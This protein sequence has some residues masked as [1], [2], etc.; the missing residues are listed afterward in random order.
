MSINIYL[1]SNRDLPRAC[2]LAASVYLKAESEVFFLDPL[3]FDEELQQLLL[4][5]RRLPVNFVD[6]TGSEQLRAAL[7]EMKLKVIFNAC[8]MDLC[9]APDI[10]PGYCLAAADSPADCLQAAAAAIRL[11]YLFMA[12]PRAAVDLSLSQGRFPMLWFGST[13]KLYSVTG[14]TE[15]DHY[16][17]INSSAAL[18]K[19]FQG[20]GLE[21]DYLV[22]YNSADLLG[23]STGG[24]ALGKLRVRG[25]S[26]LL[27]VLSSYRNI[28]PYDAV[29][30]EPDPLTIER[31]LNDMVRNIGLKPRY[32][33]VLASPAVIPFI[34]GEK[35]AITAWAEEMVRD[36]HL[37]LNSDLFFDLAEGRLMSIQP[38]GF[39][40]S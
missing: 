34:C 16:T 33:A 38:A 23:K 2:S 37:R 26:L 27:T 20:A 40:H 30:E 8:E 1:V 18:L 7:V 13:E 19:Y 29:A 36:I 35:K 32:L 9:T 6:T 22:L 28:F 31:Q 11:G 12:L 21:N 4:L 10:S 24:D 5:S 3:N 39:Q 17:I 25:L 14:L 15:P